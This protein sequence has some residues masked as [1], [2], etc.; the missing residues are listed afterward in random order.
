MNHSVFKIIALATM[1]IDHIGVFLVDENTLF[2]LILRAIGRIA[3]VMF[4]FM[5]AEGFHKTRDV[6]KYF[7]RLL[8]YA[9]ALEIVV[10]IYSLISHENLIFRE[11]VIWP[12]VFGLGSLILLNQKRIWLR[13]LVIPVV[14]LAVLLDIQYSAYGVVFIIIFGMYRNIVAQFLMAIGLNLI[15]IT[16]FSTYSGNQGN[17]SVYLQWFSMV[18]FIF[19]FLYNGKKSPKE[20]KALLYIYYPAHIAVLFIIGYF[21]K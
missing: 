19:I 10:A 20:S 6:K 12:L 9:S 21:I 7:L 11:N 13:F 2:Y 4:A 1:T 8:I 18:A 17:T 14:F 16:Y 15:F 3:F 5:I